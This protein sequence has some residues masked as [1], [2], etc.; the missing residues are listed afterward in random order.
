MNRLRIYPK[1]LFWGLFFIVLVL[2][3]ILDFLWLYQHVLHY[4]F[5]FQ[6]FVQFFALFGLFGCMA[7]ILI[8]KGM[9]YFIVTDE[10]YYDKK[11]RRKK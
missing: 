9:G 4:H 3:L 11:S 7:L 6:Y 5:T 8:A 1:R 2:S 10:N